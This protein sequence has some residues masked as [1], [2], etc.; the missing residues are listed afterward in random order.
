MVFVAQID[1]DRVDANNLRCNQHAFK[2]AMR[3]A[4]QVETIF[5]CPRLSL[6]N[7]HRHQTWRGFRFHDAPFAP[8]RESGTAQATQTGVLHFGD[9]VFR[10]ALPGDDIAV[11]LVATVRLILCIVRKFD[12]DPR[13]AACLLVLHGIGNAFNGCTT[14]RIVS[15]ADSGRF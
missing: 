4:F 12:I 6:V 1:V 8:G 7:I 13:N 15:H 3:I 10:I 11:C 5:E 2:K 14:E 9:Y